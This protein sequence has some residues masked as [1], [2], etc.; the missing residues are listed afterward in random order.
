MAK[1]TGKEL[2]QH[3]ISI[4]EDFKSKHKYI[5][6]FK[7]F[8][9]WAKSKNIDLSCIKEDEFIGYMCLLKNEYNYAGSTIMSM[10]SCIKKML[11]AYNGIDS[12]KWKTSMS[13]LKK[14]KEGSVVKKSR[15]FEDDDCTEFLGIYSVFI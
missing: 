15:V 1:Q 7:E 5:R 14:W 6:L 8:K 10:S 3:R 2:M 12:S 11:W 9:I 13:I 4:I